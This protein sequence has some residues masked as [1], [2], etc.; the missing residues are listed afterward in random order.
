MLYVWYIANLSNGDTIWQEESVYEFIGE[1]AFIDGTLTRRKEFSLRRLR[2]MSSS[3]AKSRASFIEGR[4]DA[5]N[6][7][8]DLLN[9][10]FFLCDNGFEGNIC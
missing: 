5:L 10:E 3:D 4:R 6:G 7:P 8:K 1:S 2:S 9:W